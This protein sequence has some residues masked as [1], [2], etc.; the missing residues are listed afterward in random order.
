MRNRQLAYLLIC[1]LI[2]LF[3]GMGLF[4]LLP[5]YAAQFG[6]T[7]TTLGLY[8]AIA[9]AASVAGIAVTGWL[10]D[11]LPR[12]GLFVVGGALGVPALALLGF[13]TAL[14]QVVLLTAAIWFFGAVTITLVSVFTGRVADGG[15]RG[16]SFSLM[17]A[18]YPLG[19]DFG[20]AAV[21]QLVAWGGYAAMFGA[22]AA[23]WTA[24]PLVGLAGLKATPAAG[25]A[26][27]AEVRG[28]GPRLGR[29]F[30]LL[31]AAFLGSSMAINVSRLGTS[32]S[33]EALAFS[34]GAIASTAVVSGLIAAPVAVLLGALSDR[35]G[36][37]R[38]LLGGYALAVG[39][40]L[41]LV[42]ATQLWHFW[43]AATLLFVAWCANASVS[44][45]LATELLAPEA[46][47]RGLPRLNATDSLA[48]IL[49][50]AGAGY[51]VDALGAT[52]L[53]LIAAGVA[54]LAAPLLGMA[55]P[56]RRTGP[57]PRPTPNRVR[58]VGR[59]P[60]GARGSQDTT[61]KRRQNVGRLCG[62]LVDVVQSAQDV[63]VL[64]RGGAP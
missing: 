64:R 24:L 14:W 49:G 50:F 21:G 20:G 1:N 62:A 48:S 42:V 18:A 63:A 10:G 2:P 6:A 36:H 16:A 44:S 8:Y 13:A 54:A 3:V 43:A 34:P 15:R 11:L 5:L 28:A 39:G 58:P 52:G 61:T 46:L 25:L 29:A 9:Y 19:T 7:P 59:S 55:S 51:L 47:G 41:L 33:M 60:P 30:S 12:R 57:S 37:R 17:F 4:P 32:L 38:V 35:L 56:R 31:L 22:L 53:F 26:P 45:A 23:V 27:A 40:A